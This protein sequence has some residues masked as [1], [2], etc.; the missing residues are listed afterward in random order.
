[1]LLTKGTLKRKGNEYP[2][3]QREPFL[4]PSLPPLRYNQDSVK[5]LELC[6][7]RYSQQ[8]KI[9]FPFFGF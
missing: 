3:V 9:F 5:L 2:D 8:Q 4:I 1:M 7:T 6:S